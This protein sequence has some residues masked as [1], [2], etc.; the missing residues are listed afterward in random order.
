MLILVMR[1]LCWL[2]TIKCNIGF[3]LKKVGQKIFKR[4]DWKKS[5]LVGHSKK[6]GIDTIITQNKKIKLILKSCYKNKILKYWNEK[7]FGIIKQC[8]HNGWS[9]K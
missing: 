1:S 8:Y 4:R 6:I 5:K 2:V 7:K 3:R 9:V